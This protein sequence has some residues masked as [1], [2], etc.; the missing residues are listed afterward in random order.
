MTKFIKYMH[1]GWGVS[2][3]KNLKGKH[4][5]YCLCYSCKNFRPNQED[6]CYLAQ[7]NYEFCVLN[8][9]VLPV[10]ECPRF[11]EGEPDLSKL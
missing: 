3:R 8:G 1:H 6:N 10:W 7:K 2:V 9:M 5:K 11:K 4:N